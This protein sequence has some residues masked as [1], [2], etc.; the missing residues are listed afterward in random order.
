MSYREGKGLINFIKENQKFKFLN[1]DFYD[2]INSM[3]CIDPT[4]RITAE[5][6]MKHSWFANSI[7]L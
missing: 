2:L 3:L 7:L 1:D 4:K 6:A 5:K